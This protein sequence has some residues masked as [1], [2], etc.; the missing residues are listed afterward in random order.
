VAKYFYTAKS[1]SGE[2]RSGFLEAKDE[3]EL[4]R[5]LRQDG[6]VLVSSEGKTDAGKSSKINIS[7]SNKVSLSEK[8]MFT[9]NLQIM[10]KAGISLPRSLRISAAQA[11][12]NR[13]K[14]VLTSM[15]DNIDKGQA[16]SETISKYPD[17][18]SDVFAS[19]VRVGEESGTLEDVLKTLYNQLEREHGLKSKIMGAM[20]YPVV[21]LVAMIGVGILMMIM[22]IPQLAS[23]FEELGAKLPA[24]T[25]FV[26]GLAKFMEKNVILFLVCLAV[27]VIS[28]IRF[29]KTKIGKRAIDTI[30]LKIPL[31]SPIVK[32]TNSAY[33]TRTLS[34]LI[35]AGV[36][37]VSALG[38]VS[39]ALGNSYYKTA[40]NEAAERVSKG[41]KLSEAMIPYQD[42]Y[43]PMVVQMIEVGEETGQTAEILLNLADFYE[44]EVTEATK[45]L[46]SVVEPILM[47]IIGSIVGFFAISMIQPMYSI[48]ETI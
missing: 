6:Y 25:L 43:P 20:I 46:S 5:A 26:F 1:F 17:V 21:I 12:G 7:F 8:L 16:F 33:T 35:N 38:I 44:E 37:I 10:I 23:T 24:T 3:T 11:R 28:V 29:T 2:V 40:M 22:V 47:L 19:M 9:K 27:F 13:F 41:T 45:N 14:T 42:I 30:S 48:L 32:K 31:I 18:F 15:A 4:A 34:S 36:P 39:G